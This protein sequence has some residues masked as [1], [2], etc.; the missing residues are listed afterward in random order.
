M[1]DISALHNQF[2]KELKGYVYSRTKDKSD[3][4]DILQDVFVKI[5]LK[6]EQINEA[7][8]LRQYLYG[9]VRNS[10][11]DYFRSKKTHLSITEQNVLHTEAEEDQ[12]TERIT[13][14]CVQRFIHQ[15]PEKYRSAL[16]STEFENVPQKELAVKLDISYSALKSRV[17]RGRVM[18]K[19][20]L[21]NCCE[22]Q[23]DIYGNI[24]E[25]TP[26]TCNCN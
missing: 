26:R 17:Q 18:L 9:I 20:M 8:N 24:L 4:E 13:D 6:I 15:L 23:N 12:L 7:Q 22:I 21:V 19:E 3:T 11:A 1:T 25:A 5:I 14:R 10:V 2:Y 16:L